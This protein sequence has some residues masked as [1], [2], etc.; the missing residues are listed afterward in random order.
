MNQIDLT[1][2]VIASAVASIAVL[3]S[4]QSS[5]SASPERPNVIVIM[6]DDQGYGEFSCNGNPITETPNIDRLASESVRLTDFHVAPMCTPTRGQLLTGLDAFRNAAINVSSGRTLLKHD[7]ETMANVF[8][9][10]GYRTGIFGKWHL[11]DNYPFR[12]QDR[13]F[14]ETLWF[15]SSHINSVPDF[16]D[17]DYFAD[18][19]LHNGE[20]KQYRGYCTDVFFKEATQWIDDQDDRPF[21]TYIAL[22][23][24]HWPWFVPD[25][26]RGP[27]RE[28]IEQNPAVVEHLSEQKRSELVSFLAMGA[29]IDDNV[30]ALD[31]SLKQ[32]D[33]F[34][35][36]IVV[37]LTD[38]GSTMGQ[39]YFNAGMRGKKTQLWEGGHRVPCFI[40]WPSGLSGQSRDVDELTHVQDL[41][42]TLADLS[43]VNDVPEK[44]DG[45]SLAPVLRGEQ[46]SLD[47]RMLV[48]NYSRMPGF[49]V[50]YTNVSPAIPKRNGAAVLWRQWRLLENRRLYDI[51]QD[52]HQDHNV[53]AEHPEVVNRMRSHLQNWWLGVK[54]DVMTPQR[55][56]IGDD[57]E[58]PTMLTACEWL[59]VFVDQQRQIRRGDL[60][61]G[62][63]HLRVAEPGQYRI[64]L[65]RWPRESGLRLTD[66]IPETPVT[67][68]TFVAG[69]SLPIAAAKLEIAG[70]V[71][72][73]EPASDQQS[74]ET[75]VELSAGPI[76]MR[77]TFLDDVGSEICGAYY[78][79]VRRD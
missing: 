9:D 57:A 77:A 35:N 61:N 27:V 75:Q 16:W 67:D 48:I 54:D 69:E 44:L 36:T 14:E 32:H 18:T 34:E 49:R 55:V 76:E 59:D 17:N 72:D 30:G 6:T 56:V 10:A 25:K 73:L 47:D 28:A 26:Y 11:G 51:D 71:I 22:N 4:A 5:Q 37:F 13:G 7:L 45:V 53:A 15:P 38:N 12:P 64:E 19:Y 29:S 8:Q 3:I 66:K 2:L 31:A 43:G 33:L 1:R 39:D 23:A 46:E 65:R 21:F 74:F 41:L 52:P 78:V 63:W 62:T 40:R 42:P 24:A 79:Y 70:K 68:G 20:R 58:N 60:K 50:Q